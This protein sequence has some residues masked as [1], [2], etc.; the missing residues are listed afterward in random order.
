MIARSV[1]TPLSV[2]SFVQLMLTPLE[3]EVEF[4]FIS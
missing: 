1:I 3:V 2:E 4:D